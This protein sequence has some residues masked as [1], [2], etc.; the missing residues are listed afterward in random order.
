MTFSKPHTSGRLRSR[1]GLRRRLFAETLEDRRLL[2]VTFQF[3]YI[4]GQP[5]GFNDPVDA[6]RYRAALESAANRLGASL[7]HDAT[8]Q[9][10][11]ASRAYDGSQL[12]N[13]TSAPAAVAPAGAFAHGVIPDKI[14]RGADGNGA[15]ADGGLEV[16]FFDNTDTLS[17]VTNPA[18]VDSNDEID[19]QAVMY[20]ELIH[21]I[22][23]ASATNPDGS[24]DSGNGI[25]TPGTWTPLDEFLSD[26]N[27][28]RLIDANP[29]SPTAF[30]MDTSAS[31]WPLHSRGGPGPNNG[32]FFDG[33]I[34]REVYGGPVPL[35]S[36]AASTGGGGGTFLNDQNI[37]VAL[38]A[39]M[40]PEPFANRSTADSLASIIDLPSPD[41]PED[42][43]QTTHIWVSGR[44]LELDFDFGTEYDIRTFHFWNYFGEFY[45]VDDIDM[46]F[47]SASGA[48][49]GTLENLEP[50]LG[51]NGVGNPIFAEDFPV[52][53]SG[54]A[55]FVNMRLAGSTNQ[56]DFNNIGF[57][58]TGVVP[59]DNFS[60]P[61]LDSE[62]FQT[63]ISVFSPQTHLMSHTVVGNTVPQELTLLEKAILADVGILFRESLPPSVVAPPQVT[64]EG[65]VHGGLDHSDAGLIAFL[66][67]VI[68]TDLLD[69]NPI[70]T[71]DA[72]ALFPLG[73]TTVTFTATDASGNNSNRA[74][75]VTVVD[76]TPPQ[77]DVT[78]RSV[79]YEATG[80]GGV[81]G[82]TL[83]FQVTTSDLVDPNPVLTFT[84]GGS[85]FPFGTTTE[86]FRSTDFSGNQSTI[87]VD[88]IVRDTTP[89]EFSLPS[90]VTIQA[91]LA[92]GADL[93]NQELINLIEASSSD[94][95]DDTLTIQAN[96]TIFPFGTT[97]VTFT[98]SD[99]RG[100]LASASTALT[101]SGT[102]I[103]NWS[104]PDDIVFGTPLSATQLNAAANVPGTFQY[105]PSAGQLLDAGQAQTLSVTF[106]PDD[107]AAFDPVTTTVSINVAAA[108][109]AVQ[110]DDPDPIVF[111]TP[112]GAQQLNASASV[113]GTFSYTPQA[114]EVLSA[115]AGQPLQVTFTPDSFN[116]N[117]V[118]A[119]VAINVNAAEDFGDAPQ[120]YPVLRVDDGARH[121]TTSLRLGVDVDFDPDG[122]PNPAADGDGDDDDGVVKIADLVAVDTDDTTAS[123]LV[124][125]SDAGKLDAWIDFNQDGD[126]SD[127]GEQV[128][129]S[130][131]VVAGENV[132]GYTIPAGS[133]SGE[134][135]ARFRISSAGGLQPTGA[136]N[137]GEVEDYLL[138]VL[139]GAAS[140]IPEVHSVGDS[141]T[142]IT[143]SGHLVVQS[144]PIALFRAP[145]ANV[146]SMVVSGS[147]ADESFTIAD[148]GDF[149]VPLGGLSL[150][151]GGGTNTLV[152]IGNGSSVNLTDGT[153]TADGFQI[154]DLSDT[155]A[156]A[157]IVDTSAVT[158]LAPTLQ[159]VSI[160]AGE[161][162][163][164]L[165]DDAKL[166]QMSAPAT[167]GGR[168]FVA[169][170]SN[171]GETV[172]ANLPHPWQNFLRTGDVNNDGDVS[173]SDALRIINELGRREYSDGSTE[174]LQDPLDVQS[175]PNVYFD[176][177][178]DD[179]ATALDALRV[180]NEMARLALGGQSSQAE[181]VVAAP[182]VSR[183]TADAGVTA[184]AI[185]LLSRQPSRQG[186][187]DHQPDVK[188]PNLPQLEQETSEGSLRIRA[189]DEWLATEDF[190]ELQLWW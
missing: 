79:T 1:V 76:T 98:V 82:V 108:D 161:G 2:A 158:T 101:V 123:F 83:P 184:E 148:N 44:D 110:W 135:A 14:I 188:E 54:P 157:L 86:T 176:H 93:N 102:T 22:G 132:L 88:I 26:S 71:N 129:A 51:G 78:P 100:N 77:I 55:R 156:V 140:P 106:T 91:N 169:A 15:S 21:A 72:P 130:V 173:A 18:E 34:A 133:L 28:N 27:G 126:W 25:T 36:P 60:V 56:V 170:T 164:I 63:G 139:S 7:L 96:P 154:I 23:F 46:T 171:S 143:D 190:D 39:S 10:D 99:T 166:W 92:G 65:N 142:I 29:F 152:V 8:I 94:L 159:V 182:E 145:V 137:D 85:V 103:V 47:R 59:S 150:V 20:R 111:G 147:T 117:V 127:A 128:F 9:M 167:I 37:T 12:A 43:A 17:Y 146:G 183:N 42:H 61:H 175:W 186:S 73:P 104:N 80:P 163:Q 31:G 16:F 64:L 125:A 144:D 97:N 179:R 155:D 4:V 151:G 121:A 30:R 107:T 40:A 119:S 131:D 81:S 120:N 19:F 124:A 153:I 49:V 178:G 118:T 6:S 141:T 109:P 75:V 32:L 58:T 11:V 177:N 189:I 84:G 116:Y 138:T 87:A 24:D 68:A 57:S 35:Y 67:S 185:E 45:D 66:D 41:S 136:A 52:S 134:T 62:G 89:P 48:I 162:D 165:V 69:P 114:G 95:V 105:T 33:P 74:S 181:Q 149:Q 3:N 13:A 112:L 122:Q 115:G 174:N 160:I 172:Q 53:L 168:F 50:E 187:F 5:I 113:A 38:G 180:I 70:V 90:E